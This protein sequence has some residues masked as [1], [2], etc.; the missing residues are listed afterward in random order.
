MTIAANLS[1][2]VL[3]LHVG[4]GKSPI[5]SQQPWVYSEN[6]ISEQQASK[7]LPELRLPYWK[8]YVMQFAGMK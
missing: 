7:W 3:T 8:L 1:H 6:P 4:P 5:C 2:G